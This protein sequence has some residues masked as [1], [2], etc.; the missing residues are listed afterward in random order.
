MEIN[1][2]LIHFVQIYWQKNGEKITGKTHS[3]IEIND[4]G[5]LL[6]SNFRL[7]DSG[8]YSCVATSF[9]IERVATA[10]VTVVGE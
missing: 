10:Q 5:E 3:Q 1:Y 8:N 4:Y 7:T 9:G 2:R 6:I